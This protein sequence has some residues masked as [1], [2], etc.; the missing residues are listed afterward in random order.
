MLSAPAATSRNQ[1]ACEPVAAESTA[2][3]RP[4][5]GA[6]SRVGQRATTVGTDGRSFSGVVASRSRCSVSGSGARPAPGAPELGPG[7]DLHARE[8]A[9]LDERS[10]SPKRAL[11]AITTSFRSPCWH[12]TLADHREL[13]L[14]RVAADESGVAL[15]HQASSEL[16]GFEL[17]IA[18][19]PRWPTVDSAVSG[20][21]SAWSPPP[22]PRRPAPP[23]PP[24]CE[25]NQP[26]DGVLVQEPA[27]PGMK[28][29]R[30]RAMAARNGTANTTPGPRSCGRGPRRQEVVISPASFR[31]STPSR[32][33]P[34][35][36]RAFNWGTTSVTMWWPK[37]VSIGER[38]SERRVGVELV[39][40]HDAHHLGARSV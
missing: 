4:R 37:G 9:Q 20:S 11:W 10:R 25:H 24:R 15:V 39:P 5:R 28:V 12:R 8:A 23:A 35:S 17:W 27:D 18:A 34:L 26:V 38:G 31:Y 19:P 33:D 30:R 14:M 16:S 6:M 3:A 22:S 21:P 29:K 40:V 13:R 1:A 7:V 32:I 36:W 2:R